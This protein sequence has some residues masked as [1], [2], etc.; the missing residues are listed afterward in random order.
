MMKDRPNLLTQSIYKF[1]AEELSGRR[2]FCQCQVSV[3][4]CCC[5]GGVCW[6]WGYARQLFSGF[7]LLFQLFFHSRFCITCFSI[8]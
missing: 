2:A 8:L 4:C 3:R 6:V 7:I 5:S 1:V